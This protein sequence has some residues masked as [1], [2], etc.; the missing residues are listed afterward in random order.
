MITAFLF[1]A[2]MAAG[3]PNY[4]SDLRG[5]AL[6]D[7]F[8]VDSFVFETGEAYECEERDTSS[9]KTYKCPLRNARVT[10]TANGV[11]KSVAITQVSLLESSISGKLYREYYFRGT[12]EEA[13]REVKLDSPVVLSLRQ[14]MKT[15]ARLWGDLAF[16]RYAIK[17][18][19]EATQQ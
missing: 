4:P 16:Q 8:R 5:V 17:Y 10:V 18:G 13:T 3:I 12:W 7:V 2:A 6:G 19:I 9:L 14:I 1:T 15:P 11:A